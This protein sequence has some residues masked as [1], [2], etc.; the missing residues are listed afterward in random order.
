MKTNNLIAAIV[1]FFCL[2]P[3]AFGQG[4]LT[5][6][7]APAPIMKSLDQIEARTIVNSANTPGDTNNVFIISQ[8]GSYYLTMNVVPL[9]L[10]GGNAKNGIEI[11][12]NNVSLDLNGFTLSGMAGNNGIYIPNAQTNL[13]VRNGTISSWGGDGVHSSS[14][15]SLNLVFERLNVSASGFGITSY[16]AAVVRDCNSGN[17][18]NNGI[19]CGSGGVVSGSTANNNGGS[20]IEMDGGGTVVGCTVQN[21]VG[22]GIVVTPGTVS[23][24]LVQNNK[25]C[26]IEVDAAGSTVIGNTCI[27]NNLSNPYVAAISIFASNN[28]VEDNHVT[29]SGYAGIGVFILEVNNVIIKNNV[30]GNGANNYLNV[31]GQIVG[32]LINTTGAITNVNP[33]ANFSF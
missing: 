10:F 31:S 28:R 16:G 14:S 33:W 4:S 12:A 26:G 32:P 29:A 21:N 2:L 23:G 15:V 1:P 22:D 30:S 11:T 13:T 3:S 5:P 20:G 6:P 24:C 18:L 17:N 27:S 8:P 7:G 9:R 19:N 25:Y